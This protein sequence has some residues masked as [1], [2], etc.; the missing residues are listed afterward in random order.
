[1]RSSRSRAAQLQNTFATN[2]PATEVVGEENRLSCARLR[3]DR[4]EPLPTSWWSLDDGG[5]R[6]DLREIATEQE[7][8]RA[9]PSRSTHAMLPSALLLGRML[10]PELECSLVANIVAVCREVRELFRA[11]GGFRHHRAIGKYG[12]NSAVV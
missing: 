1:M 12:G 9:R 10:L 4:L 2:L 7:R 6:P 11:P 3:P 8:W 5:C